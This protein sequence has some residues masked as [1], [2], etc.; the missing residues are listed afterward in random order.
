MSNTFAGDR[1]AFCAENKA[2][3]LCRELPGPAVVSAQGTILRSCRCL[4]VGAT[5]AVTRQMPSPRT[6]KVA[7]SAG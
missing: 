1:K 5:L 3:A 7:R 6:G 2:C 4:A